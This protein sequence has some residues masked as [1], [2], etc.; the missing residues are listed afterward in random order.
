MDILPIAYKPI[1]N[2]YNNNVRIADNNVRIADNKIKI[3]GIRYIK[4]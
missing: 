2:N 4:K 1:K 3:K